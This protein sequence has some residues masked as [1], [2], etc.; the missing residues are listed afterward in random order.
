MKIFVDRRVHTQKI[1]IPDS[2]NFLE[3]KYNVLFNN[4][5]LVCWFVEAIRICA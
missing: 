2:I 5:V 4:P 1:K 3:E